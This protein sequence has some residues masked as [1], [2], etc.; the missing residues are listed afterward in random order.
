MPWVEG[1]EETKKR[2][3]E[4][5][6]E[7]AWKELVGQDLSEVSRRSDTEFDE[8]ER[9]FKI[10]FMGD[11]YLV[12]PDEMAIVTVD[13]EFTN[14]FYA[15]LIVHYLIGAK[16]VPLANEVI[17]F[18]ELYGGD[19]YYLAFKN[20]AIEMI[21]RE[22][23]SRPEELVKKGREM[24]GEEAGIGDYSVRIPVFPKMPITIVMWLGDEEV[25]TSA[26]ILFDK[27][28]G[29]HL[30]TEDIAAIG[31]NLARRLSS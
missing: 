29:E 7:N 23:E 3:F 9:V 22:F 8:S 25:P 13:G 16:D 12:K 27:T 28:A 6:F 11:D 5:A 1:S 19:V 21:R 26:N 20:R 30:H 4:I 14:P 17:S 10:K 2:D 31:E 18:R 15:F 24:G